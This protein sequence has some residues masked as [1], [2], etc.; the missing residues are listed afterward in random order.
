[1]SIRVFV[2]QS[3]AFLLPEKKFSK[4]SYISYTRAPNVQYLLVISGVGLGVG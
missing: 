3:T 4:I 1:M 2:L